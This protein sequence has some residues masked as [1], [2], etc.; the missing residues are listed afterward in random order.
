MTFCLICCCGNA[1]EAQKKSLG[2]EVTLASRLVGILLPSIE[3][4]YTDRVLNKAKDLLNDKR[5]LIYWAFELLPFSRRYCA[6]EKQVRI[7]LY[8]PRHYIF[9]LFL[10]LARWSGQTNISN[11]S[12][13]YSMY[14]YFLCQV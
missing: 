2:K 13:T 9:I 10:V 8:S 4:I 1:S 5:H 6:P 11:K 12:S 7:F 14:L 3:S